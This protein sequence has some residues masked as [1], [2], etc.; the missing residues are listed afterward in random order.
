MHILLLHAHYIDLLMQIITNQ[1]N[2]NQSNKIT[3]LDI[4]FKFILMALQKIKNLAYVVLSVQYQVIVVGSTK[5]I[6]APYFINF[7]FNKILISSQA[8]PFCNALYYIS[9]FICFFLNIF[10]K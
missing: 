10:N 6:P 2:L 7:S 9:L 4:I 5:E 3:R 8:F 1:L